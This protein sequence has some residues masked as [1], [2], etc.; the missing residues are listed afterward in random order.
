[1][2]EIERGNQTNKQTNKQASWA[3]SQPITYLLTYFHLYDYPL[4]LEGGTLQVGE[5]HTSVFCVLCFFFF[6]NMWGR[7]NATQRNATQLFEGFL[8]QLS[9]GWVGLGFTQWFEFDLVWFN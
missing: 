7:S 5:H 8:G 2:D 9:M 4:R 1:M 3:F 6:F